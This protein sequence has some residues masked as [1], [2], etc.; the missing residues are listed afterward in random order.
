MTDLYQSLLFREE[1]G[2]AFVTVNRP[3]KLNALNAAVISELTEAFREIRKDG[4]VRAAVLTGA[5]EKAFVAGADIAELA[6]LDPGGASRASEAGQK[7]TLLLED[8]GK[9]VIA[10][11]NGYALGGGLE[12]A[13][14]CTL[15]IAVEGAKLGQPEV[16]LGIICGY[17]GTQRLPRLV[18][19][20]RALEMLLTGEPVDAQEAWRIG[21]VNRVVKR[22]AILEEARS[23]AKKIAASGP[24][25]VEYSLRL[26][27]EGLEKS[28]EDALGHENALFSQCF[29]TGDMK[30]GMKAF[31]EKRPPKFTGR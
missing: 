13:M 15:R 29:E 4:Q 11:I 12:L 19:R 5:G 16:K 10:A 30:E 14:A 27:R 25:A 17:G 23:L 7:L 22:E 31:L 6:A 18:G 9:P 28:L 26:V 2:I 1:E 20:G 24:I 21:L 8:L 3:D